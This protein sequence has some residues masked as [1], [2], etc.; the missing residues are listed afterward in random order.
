MPYIPLSPNTY[1][2]KQ[3]LIN[4]DR[5]IFNAKEDSILLFSKQVIGFS[6][7][8]SFHFDTSQDDNSSFI[9][10]SP[11][12]YLGLNYDNTLPTQ[13]AVQ[14]I[15]RRIINQ[16]M[17][18]MNDI[19]FKITYMVSVPGAPTAPNPA[20]TAALQGRYQ[21]FRDIMM[22]LDAILSSNTKLV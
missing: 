5:L 15:L 2:G 8:G 13:S 19:E 21:N 11:N 4:S 1:Q 7:N 16:I 3:V 6:T 9:V 20:N 22:E 18:L 14:D 10:N 17:G 12:I